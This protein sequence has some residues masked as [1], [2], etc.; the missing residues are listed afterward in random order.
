[1]KHN[2]YFMSHLTRGLENRP[3]QRLSALAAPNTLLGQEATLPEPGCGDATLPVMPWRGAPWDGFKRI[4]IPDHLSV[5][6]RGPGLSTFQTSQVIPRAAESGIVCQVPQSS[7][8]G[9]SQTHSFWPWRP[10]CRGGG[11]GA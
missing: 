3:E 2:I 5:S 11:K 9:T 7:H 4:A 8:P 10:L 6:G 1:M